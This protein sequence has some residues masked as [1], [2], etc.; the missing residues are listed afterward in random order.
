[1]FCSND[2][3]LLH[4][5]NSD[6]H[7][8]ASLPSLHLSPHNWKKFIRPIALLIAS[9]FCLEPIKD[10]TKKSPWRIENLTVFHLQPLPIYLPKS[11]TS[12]RTGIVAECHIANEAAHLKRDLSKENR[13]TA[14]DHSHQ[15][16]QGLCLA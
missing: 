8:L 11:L 1:M 6:N 14:A 5:T 9:R 15:E 4:R 13:Q 12:G 7:N 3:C 16:I 2:S 10:C